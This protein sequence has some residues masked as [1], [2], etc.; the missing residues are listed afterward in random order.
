[1]IEMDY[2][3]D[4]SSVASTAKPS[5]REC[6]TGGQ[7]HSLAFPVFLPVPAVVATGLGLA[8]R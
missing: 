7:W 3:I 5:R 6:A 8:G 4:G 1:M 2:I